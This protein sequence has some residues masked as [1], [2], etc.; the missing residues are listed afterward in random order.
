M[1]LIQLAKYL[2]R[3]MEEKDEMGI[4]NELRK[5][6]LFKKDFSSDAWFQ[7]PSILPST[8]VQ[9]AKKQND[10]EHSAYQR[11]DYTPIDAESDFNNMFRSIGD[12]KPMTLFFNSGMATIASV[13]YYLTATK[14]VKAIYLGENAYFE[15]KWLFD[16]YGNATYFNEYNAKIDSDAQV[17]WLEYP[18]NC[19]NPSK[20]PFSSSPNLHTLCSFFVD[21]CRNNPS[22]QRYLVIDYTLS[23]LPFPIWKFIK[24]IPKN[25]SIF[26]ITS[27]QKHRTYGLDVINAG[28]LTTYEHEMTYSYMKRIRAILGASITQESLWAAPKFDSLVINQLIMDSGRNAR[29]LYKKIYKKIP[30]CVKI[31]YAMNKN[32]LTSFIF[33]QIDPQ[34]MKQSTKQPYFSER[35]ISHLILAA[36]KQN[37]IVI[38]GTSFGFP[39]TRIFKN[40]ERYHNTDSLRIAV[41]FDEHMIK[42]VDKAIIEGIKNFCYEVCI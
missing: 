15:T 1:R 5:K 26:L 36:K 35:L 31:Y 8:H 32:F 25:L 20:Y 39:F 37:A 27:L 10:E 28:A 22:Q 4:Y 41:G 2:K 33:L 12:I 17:L 30:G 19:T 38:H 23:Y 3:E 11:A 18:I 16:D 14:K 42:N 21:L 7:S 24:K 9:R 40:S 29:D 34:V 6:F 13:A